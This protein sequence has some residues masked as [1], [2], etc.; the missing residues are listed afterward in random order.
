MNPAQLLGLTE[1]KRLA[2]IGK[3][4]GRIALHKGYVA[5]DIETTK[6]EGDDDEKSRTLTFT[7]STGT[8]D[9][10]G[11]TIN[12]RGFVDLKTFPETG[13]VLWAHN[14]TMPPV[15]RPTKAWVSKGKVKATAIF[16]PPDLDHPMGMGF[17]DTVLRYFKL[18]ALK[19][20]SV[21]FIPLEFQFSEEMQ[22]AIDFIKHSLLEFSP[23]PIPANPEA[24]VELAAGDHAIKGFFDVASMALDGGLWLPAPR[25][26]I[27]NTWKALSPLYEPQVSFADVMRSKAVRES[28]DRAERKRPISWARAH[29]EGTPVANREAEWDVEGETARAEIIDLVTM[30]A[31][32]MGNGD[33]PI[34]FDFRLLHHGADGDHALIWRGLKQA[35]K[36]L[37]L[38]DDAPDEI[39]EGERKGA[40]IHLARHYREDFNEEPPEFKAYG[41]DE[42]AE[43]FPADTKEPGMTWDKA[44]IEDL[45]TRLEKATTAKAAP[46]APAKTTP[47]AIE[48]AKAIVDSALGDGYVPESNHEKAQLESFVKAVADLAIKSTAKPP[49]GG[50]PELDLPDL[51]DPAVKEAVK[52]LIAEMADEE[53][54][55]HF[56]GEA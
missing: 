33:D 19:S 2:K 10:D 42:L 22:N 36:R 25:S 55:K 50:D 26:Q 48:D 46:P 24:L 47:Q 44:K 27:E 35:M 29:A 18:G 45:L 1:F 56:L 5:D 38:G 15:A 52:D 39:P 12:P 32:Q 51:N 6:G 53:Y 30:S 37:L 31:W 41:A 16:N 49:G 14:H 21:G 8:R 13:V 17:G 54:R 28:A 11:D 4:A 9:R 40:Y 23:V 34:K 43:L 7:I 3:D 20:V